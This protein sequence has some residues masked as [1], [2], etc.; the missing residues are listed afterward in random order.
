MPT[1]TD[2]KLIYNIYN[3]KGEKIA[4]EKFNTSIKDVNEYT[5][6]LTQSVRV[7]LVNQRQG[8]ASTK[9][10]GEVTGST[11]KIYRQKGTGRARHGSIKAPIFIGGGIV[12]GPRPR[13]FN[14]S[15]TKKM[16]K[17]AFLI[18]VIDKINNQKFLVVDKLETISAKTKEAAG[19][20]K[21]LFAKS[22]QPKNLLLINNGNKNLCLA[23][24]NIPYL[25]QVSA[26]TV[27]TYDLLSCDFVLITK[28]ALD[29]LFLRLGLSQKEKPK[30]PRVRKSVKK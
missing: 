24:R 21:A 22:Q 28:E 19:I 2:N 16:K 23:T 17:K 14:L 27:S 30:V 5:Q 25:N 6:L 18:S 10:R 8:N 20:I 11:R 1:K 7:H 12:F 4:Q 3:L 26:A 15:L 9:T 29:K 13:D